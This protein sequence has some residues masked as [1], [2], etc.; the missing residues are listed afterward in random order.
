MAA[1]SV[2]KDDISIVLCGAAG[3][4]VQTVEQ[5]LTHLFKLSG[6]NLFSTKEYMS[7]V[8]GG[9]N[10]TE[11]RVSSHKVNAFVDRIDILFP[12]NYDALKH[13]EKRISSE[14]II[15]GEKEKLID[16]SDADAYDII[17]V[18]LSDIAKEIGS[19][20]YSNIIIVGIIA[21]LF[22]VDRRFIE[23][24]LT[25]RFG[26][27]GVEIIE[28]NIEAVDRGFKIGSELVSSK[29]IEIILDKDPGVNEEIIIKG[30]DAVGLGAI[31]GGCN[32]V[33]SYP[34]TPSTPVLTFL[35]NHSKEFNVL[36]EQA[37]DEIAAINMTLG[38]WYAGARGIVTTSGGGFAL[39]EEGISLAGMLEL[40]VVVHLAQRPG[41]ATGLPTRTEQGDLLFT[42][43][44]GHGEFP[45]IIFAPGNLNDAFYLTRDAFNLADKFQIRS[46]F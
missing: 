4:G 35:A 5:L 34:M 16:D 33:S 23:D 25:K 19:A 10:S 1:L 18:A 31:A 15:I 20:I 46:L 13:I 9:S 32:F 43:F 40:P 36:V 11:L 22:N 8:R 28:K 38:A 42:L 6:Y 45:R 21:A 44:S 14:T 12:L 29:K 24:Y 17:N 41:P 37:E 7:R 30:G 2:K 27:K 39:M 3:Q 26:K